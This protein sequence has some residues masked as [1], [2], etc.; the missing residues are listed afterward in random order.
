MTTRVTRAWER[1]VET[2]LGR[3]AVGDHA[4]WEAGLVVGQQGPMIVMTIWM[5]G[6]ILGT[7]IQNTLTFGAPATQTEE[8]VA[9][10]VRTAV[11]MMHEQRSRTLA[12][13]PPPPS[14]GERPGIILPD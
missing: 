10:A 8:T 12:N 3:Y 9:N 7:T 11:A 6:P 4:V 5:P 2:A 1:W 14:N 13:L